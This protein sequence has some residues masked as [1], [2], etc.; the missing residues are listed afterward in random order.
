MAIT[1]CMAF[2]FY[3]FDFFFEVLNKKTIAM[4][5]LL[6]GDG[7]RRLMHNVTTPDESQ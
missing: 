6:Q 2:F 5:G 7:V 4:H 3:N 1:A